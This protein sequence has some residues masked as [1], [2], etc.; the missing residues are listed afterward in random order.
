MAFISSLPRKMLK[1]I[2]YK[3]NSIPYNVSHRAGTVTDLL[4]GNHPAGR[5]MR[6]ILFTDKLQLYR[7]GVGTCYLD[8]CVDVMLPQHLTEE[9][10]YIF[11]NMK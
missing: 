2:K 3:V 11:H 10:C 1:L 8:I 6:T 5:C 7:S 9:A 4:P